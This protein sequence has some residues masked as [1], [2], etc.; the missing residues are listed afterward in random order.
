MNYLENIRYYL[1]VAKRILSPEEGSRIQAYVATTGNDLSKIISILKVKSLKK[2][3]D[4][5][6]NIYYLY[7]IRDKKYVGKT[8]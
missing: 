8:P 5:K 4:K 6:N 7:S 1:Y 2:S 3:D